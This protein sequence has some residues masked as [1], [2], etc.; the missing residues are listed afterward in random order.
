M[1]IERFGLLAA[2]LCTL[3]ACGGGGDSTP[4]TLSPT[5]G[6]A[7]IGA[8]GGTVLAENGAQ[9]VFPKDALHTDT[10][11]RIAKDSTGAPPLPPGA[12]AAGAVYTITPHGGAFAVHAEVT[13]PVEMTQ[14]AD[15][16]QLLL[17][18]AEPGD[19]QW[20][21]LS[22][23]TYSNGVLRA[24]VM[25]FSFFQAIV[26]TNLSMPS[27]V[28]TLGR[29]GFDDAFRAISNNVGG[30]GIGRF[31]PDFEFNQDSWLQYSAAYLQ[32]K[33]TFPAP[34]PAVRS[35]LPSPPPPRTCLP[36]SLGHTGAAWRFLRNG[37]QALSPNVIHIPIFQVAESIYPLFDSQIHFGG[38]SRLFG[39]GEEPGFGAVHVYGYDQNTPS[40]GAYTPAGSADAW[41]L[42][43]AGNS[44][45]NDQLMWQ[46]FLLFDGEQHNGR[47][48]I[49]TTIATDCNL[50]IEAV[51]ISFQLNLASRIPAWQP[52]TG[53]QALESPVN[54]PNGLTAVLPFAEEFN[55]TSLSIAWEYSHDLV[56][57]QK[58]PV[59]AQY[60]HDNGLATSLRDPFLYG[61]YYSIVIPN[62][63]PTQ[64]GWYRAWACS[65]PIA[66][67]GGAAALPSFCMSKAPVQLVVLTERPIVTAQPGPQ[68]VQVGQTASFTVRTGGLPDASVQWQ[69]RSVVEAA[70]G[71]GTW[72]PINGATFGTYTTPP[73]TLNDN[74]MLY[75]AV[76][77][78]VLGSTA[79]DAALLTVVEQL[80]AP[81]V[82]SQPGNLN[83]TVGGT[84]VFAATVSGT[85][86][87]SYQWRRN[88]TNITGANG[89]V[90]TLNNVSALNDGNYDLVVTNRAGSV[91]SDPA[92]LLVTLGTPVALAPTIA[93]PPASI[94]VA[95]GN[96]AN[97]A[98]A[99]NGTGPY[100]YLW[101]KNGVQ[102]PIP[103][104]DLASF[105]IA[106][107]TAAD[108]GTYSVRVTNSVGTVV[109]AAATLTVSA[110]SST[111]VAPS[112]STQ[113]AT[114]V[115]LP[116]AA[117]TLA[118]A[119]S[120]SGPLSYQW[121]RNGAPVNGAT[122]AV[123]HLA[124]ISSLDAG[125]YTV[126][127]SNSAGSVGSSAA[128][129]ILVGVPAITA[130]PANASA[131][132]GNT[133]SFT[134]G[135][136]GDFPRYQ[137]TRN[138]VAIAGA[139]SASYTTPAL[140]LADS[141]AVY[142]VIVY[143]GAGLVFSNS[144]VLTVT[145]APLPIGG[146]VSGLSGAGLVLQN[147]GGDNLAVSA[148]GSF[149]F[150][151]GLAPGAAYA[152]SVLSQPSGQTCAIQNGSGTASAAVT[153]I[154]VT[155]TSTSRLAL[156]ANSGV[157]SLSILR[158]DSSTGALTS[159][160]ST[161]AGA[162]PYAIAITPNGLFA[163]VTNLVGNNVSSYSI[164]TPTGAV[165]PVGISVNSVNP[166]GIA[167][168]PLG[169]FTWVANYSASTVSAYSINGSTGQL[170][171]V[172]SPQATGLLP[173]ALAA[174]PSGNYVYVANELGNSVSVFSVNAGTGALTLLAGTIVNSVYR[175]HAIAADP[176]GR[177][178][179]VA[180]NGGSSVAAFRV[181]AST[182]VLSA[183][184]YANTG[185]SPTGV[186]VHPNGQF[187]YVTTSRGVS[188]FSINGTT[189]A[190]TAIGSP[191]AAGSNPAG[192]AID[193]TGTHLYVT[194]QGS[195]SASGFS[196]DAATGALTSLGAAVSTGS[197]PV[198]I[199]ITP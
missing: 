28:T 63:Q 6:V 18:T 86:P 56:N 152:T 35:G 151:S 57:W 168:D 162:Y 85:V 95:E 43:P 98:V 189:G 117:A 195:N 94:T 131:I 84:A 39:S 180:E 68:I 106:S 12:T 178:V 121:S 179:F 2:L 134:V 138:Q 73:T 81:I 50:L 175:P 24:P 70:F 157:N 26:L 103:N 186:A 3:V 52:Y 16:Q 79:S 49:D 125:S 14:I 161:G 141:G 185:T 54:A 174:H 104:G 82:Q 164:D 36:T 177:F 176:S 96:A 105:G 196:I 33:L 124:S 20:R 110:G 145:A 133:A 136:N 142:G 5:P 190:L 25:H 22:G 87:L 165:A 126:A 48:R 46:G 90:L 171:A 61:H 149:T 148:N 158:A 11:V 47:M 23:A 97:F 51:P 72:T 122:G 29:G 4:P 118:I 107:V 100:T 38:F 92:V 99:V 101:M 140:T 115:V 67:D 129:L 187:V 13:I 31:S 153:N 119:V 44:T 78:T 102:A 1:N 89:T 40:R 144:A 113:P 116:G 27:L 192:L 37:T 66:A 194:D 156:V 147:N 120:G 88:G 114:L 30:A 108:A 146:S 128:Q 159:I 127:V 8:A 169:R 135:A 42:P 71:I 188:T 173:Y 183:P 53:V 7:T 109:S 74:G 184:T 93:A 62:V 182:G 10:T 60:I 112:I 17:V 139:T 181:N 167:M 172:G 55:G 154:A 123:L 41:A 9:I 130:Q 76:A 137:W 160:G 150:A 65:K 58:L 199:A 191:I 59:P 143:N 32:A 83:V 45:Y 111:P 197:G 163:Y 64:A 80:A 132:A 69:K 198:G 75:R 91:T 170:A 166:Y 77:T 155:C 34:P 193:A 19:T 15:N 21:V